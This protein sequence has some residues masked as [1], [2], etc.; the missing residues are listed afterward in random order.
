MPLS[1]AVNPEA[2]ETISTDPRQ[3]TSIA[4]PAMA[5]GNKPCLGSR[6]T[7]LTE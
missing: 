4:P 6:S 1:Q 7:V 2:P 5:K 3:Q